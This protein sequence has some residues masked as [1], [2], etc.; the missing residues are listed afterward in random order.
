MSRASF[1]YC[2]GTGYLFNFMSPF[3]GSLWSVDLGGRMRVFN[4]IVAG[5]PVYDK[6]TV[7]GLNGQTYTWE[8]T[9]SGDPFPSMLDP[10]LW[11]D[12][13]T[14][15][16]PAPFAGMGLSINYGATRMV[17]KID[18]LPMGKK[19]AIGGYSQGAAV[20]SA[21]YL[22]GLKPGTTGPLESRRDDFLG[23]VCFGNPR[24]QV[25]HRGAGGQFG[26]WSG[27]WWDLSVHTGSGGAFP[28]NGEFARL[29][30]CEDK[31]VEFVAP[32]DIFA[33][34]GTS[35]TENRW[36][37][38]ISFFLGSLSPQVLVQAIFDQELDDIVSVAFQK[39][40][41]SVGGAMNYL[42][43]AA[44]MLFQIGG[45]GHTTLP[46]LGPPDVN[47]VLPAVTQVVNNTLYR[48]AVG[49]TCYQLGLKFL[50]GLAA[51]HQAAPILL[52][53]QPT[54]TANAGW[55]TTLVPPAA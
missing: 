53:S 30:G 45:N 44:G 37:T 28:D 14:V 42:I 9:P 13:V 29:T 54:T 18:A 39:A 20:A 36:T 34:N 6:G 1:F 3:T 15:D 10:Q 12:R 16:Y 55:S 43:D 50:N 24:R 22:A 17:E 2:V 33:A 21:V 26:T 51:E 27:S 48:G 19:F 46:F 40:M 25:N 32:G 5:S 47:G 41:G 38:A 11:D 23:A 52:P 4:Q 35:Q 49:D 7:A 8:V 31:W